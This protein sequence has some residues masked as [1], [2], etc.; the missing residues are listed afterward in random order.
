MHPIIALSVLEAV[1]AG[2]HPA[3]E[4]VT[5]NQATQDAIRLGSTRSVAR[6]IDR[7]TLMVRRAVPADPQEVTGLFTLVS[8]R[9]DANLLFAEAGRRAGKYAAAGVP[10]LLR[11][12]RRVMP[13]SLG[14]RMSRRLVRGA[15]RRVFAMQ[16]AFSDAGV[17]AVETDRAGADSGGLA[18]G[19]YGSGLAELL[20]TF[21]PFDGACFHVACRAN[22]DAACTWSTNQ[23]G[24]G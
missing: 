11:L 7:Y 20:R 3:G 8:R 17:S 9:P 24:E 2:D 19:L 4:S 16:V 10:G 23:D 21:T 12:L 14:R 6:Q 13:G 22:G 5:G 15:A 18:C 1:R